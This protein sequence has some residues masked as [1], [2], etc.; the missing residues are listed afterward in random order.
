MK[1]IFILILLLI[2]TI[3]IYIFFPYSPLSK[4][5]VVDKLVVK[6]S[7]RK[8]MVYSNGVIVKTYSIALGDQPVGAKEKDGDE[9]TPEGN[10]IINSK[11]GLGSSGYYKNLGVSYPSSKDEKNAKRKGF[12]PGDGIKI[13]GLQNGLGFIGRFHR[14]KDWTDGCMAVTNEEMDDLYR[15]VK[16]GTPIVINP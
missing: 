14:W 2:I 16:I 8:L 1:K 9:K 15:H 12:K 13:H 4:D 5:I 3:T 7:Q 10:Y 6:K 11:A